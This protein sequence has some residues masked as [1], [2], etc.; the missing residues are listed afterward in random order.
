M[1]QPFNVK[2][3]TVLKKKKKKLIE[4]I[5]KQIVAFQ[6]LSSYLFLLHSFN[7]HNSVVRNNSI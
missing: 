2:G 4:I 3:N 1:F 5:P 7:A 6:M